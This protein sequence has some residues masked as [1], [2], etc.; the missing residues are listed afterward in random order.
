LTQDPKTETISEQA[1]RARLDG[2]LGALV[3]VAYQD[4][5]RPARR[6]VEVL[7]RNQEPRSIDLDDPLWAAAITNSILDTATWARFEPD[8]LWSMLGGEG[9]RSQRCN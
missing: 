2:L 7:R 9:T 8:A 3:G 5:R 4:E 1:L 6:Y